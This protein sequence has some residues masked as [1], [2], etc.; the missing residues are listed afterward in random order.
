M[1]HWNIYGCWVQILAVRQWMQCGGL[2]QAPAERWV[3]VK[4]DQPHWT[5]MRQMSVQRSQRLSGVC[6]WRIS[7]ARHK[8]ENIWLQT[9]CIGRYSVV[10]NV[11]HVLYNSK[12]VDIGSH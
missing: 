8:Y 12:Q 11:W 6:E 10:T 7:V 3:C 1:P 5:V 9:T 2:I 4:Q